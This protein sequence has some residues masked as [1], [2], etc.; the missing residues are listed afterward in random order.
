ME[1]IKILKDRFDK[2]SAHTTLNGNEVKQTLNAFQPVNLEETER[3][4][5]SAPSKSCALDPIPTTLVKSLVSP[6]CP[7]IRNIINE[8]LRNAK[9]PTVFK[10]ALVRPL[11]K[12]PNLEH[13]HKNYRPVSNL[14][15][16]S[17]LI[18]QSVINQLESHFEKNNLNDEYQS[19]YRANHS[20]ETA[21]LHIVNNIL[22][23]MDNRKAVYMVMLDLSAAFDTIDHDI[24]ID[25]LSDSQGLGPD[26]IMWFESY[27]RGRTQ[28]VTVGECTSDHIQL[29]DGAVQGSKMGCRLYKKYVEPLGKMLKLS[30]C[31]FH[32]Y[33]DDNSIWKS[34]DPKSMDSIDAGLNTM[35]YTI[36][37]IRAWMFANKLCL[38]DSKTEFILFGLKRH[39]KRYAKM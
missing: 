13:V 37:Q 14:A 15:F 34:V 12:K 25:R 16:V 36:D 23:S 9:V 6:L 27:L 28:R 11:L 35:N 26:V 29:D 2:N 31:D 1:K 3:L 5:L 7:V 39:T 38:N 24:M 33:A 18:E 20:T 22:V 30:E 4:I 32:G 10:T 8:S 17:K 19:A 21:L